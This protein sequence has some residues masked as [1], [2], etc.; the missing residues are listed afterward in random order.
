MSN[1]LWLLHVELAADMDESDVAKL[2]RHHGGAHVRGVYGTDDRRHYVVHLQEPAAGGGHANPVQ[3]IKQG[4]TGGTFSS[5]HS[6][7]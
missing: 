2:V 3:A 5:L 1:D 7:V 6:C 4:L